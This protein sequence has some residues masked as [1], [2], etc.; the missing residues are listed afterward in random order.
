MTVSVWGEQEKN[1][2]CLRAGLGLLVMGLAGRE[3]GL[4]GR[5]FGPEGE[6]ILAVGVRPAHLDGGRWLAGR[7][8]REKFPFCWPADSSPGCTYK[9]QNISIC[10]RKHLL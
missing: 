5:Y 4:G 7:A 6:V 2:R 1:G 9:V 3:R 10:E 8:G